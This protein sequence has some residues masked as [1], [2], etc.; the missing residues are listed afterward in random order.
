MPG[1]FY[2]NAS[3]QPIY[4]QYCAYFKRGSNTIDGLLAS[5]RYRLH[6]PLV[7]YDNRPAISGIL[8]RNYESNESDPEFLT[9]RNNYR[10][11][12]F[13]VEYYTAGDDKIIAGKYLPFKR[14]SRIFDNQTSSYV[15][16]NQQSIF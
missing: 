14:E 12:M 8:R 15:D 5:Y 13:K 16:P 7:I 11:F 2:Y 1:E 6:Q 10:D 4:Q 3:A 9:Y